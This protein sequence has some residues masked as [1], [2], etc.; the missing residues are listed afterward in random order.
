MTKTMSENRL[1]Y[2]IYTMY[3]LYYFSINSIP[4]WL[5]LNHIVCSHQMILL[6]YLKTIQS[7]TFYLGLNWNPFKSLRHI[8]TNTTVGWKLVLFHAHRLKR[9]GFGV[10]TGGKLPCTIFFEWMPDYS[11]ISPENRFAWNAS[12][13]RMISN[14]DIKFSTQYWLEGLPRQV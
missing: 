8:S 2:N 6:N 14:W 3:Y 1:I 5:E 11:H 7:V 9:T 12:I 4:F 10:E 13:L